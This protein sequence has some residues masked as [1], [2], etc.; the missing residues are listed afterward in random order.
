MTLKNQYTI[1]EGIK[2]LAG[3]KKQ[4]ERMMAV[5]ESVNKSAGT[6]VVSVAYLGLENITINY[7]PAE[8]GGKKFTLWPVVGS[9]VALARLEGSDELHVAHVITPDVVELR[10]GDY[11]MVKGED[12]KI[13]VEKLKAAVD[14][15]KTAIQNAPVVTGDGGASFKASILA[16]LSV[17]DTGNFT[18]ILNEKV[19]HG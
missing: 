9:T 11:S 19:R 1:G 6:L 8:I 15:I 7:H 13:E 17:F 10:G 2:K 14:Q 16:S 3:K 18:Q 12:L 4:A 5:V